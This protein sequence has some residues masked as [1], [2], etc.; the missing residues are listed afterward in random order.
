[1]SASLVSLV[2]PLAFLTLLEAVV[3]GVSVAR[4]LIMLRKVTGLE[5]LVGLAAHVFFVVFCLLWLSSFAFT[6][7]LEM[8]VLEFDIIV[9]ARVRSFPL[10]SEPLGLLGVLRVSSL[11]AWSLPFGVPPQVHR[12]PGHVLAYAGVLLGASS[13]RPS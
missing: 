5:G 4:R 12:V 6:F 1:M 7:Q 10:S 2:H 8:A 13:W 9:A 3:D 11:V